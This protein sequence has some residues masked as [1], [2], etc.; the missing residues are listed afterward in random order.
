MKNV[1]ERESNETELT[2]TGIDCFEAL[3]TELRRRQLTADAVAIMTALKAGRNEIESLQ[4]AG[5][6]LYKV[7][8]R[9]PSLVSGALRNLVEPCIEAIRKA[10]PDST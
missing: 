7:Q 2:T 1:E 5:A 4:L 8:K 3:V 6:V 9:T 10:V